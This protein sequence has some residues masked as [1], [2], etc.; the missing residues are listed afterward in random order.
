MEI[1]I[2]FLL[3]M[4]LQRLSSGPGWVA[5]GV[6][7]GAGLGGGATESRVRSVDLDAVG[8]FHH[9]SWL[10][11]TCGNP[12]HIV[13]GGDCLN[14]SCPDG[15]PASPYLD[16]LSQRALPVGLPVKFHVL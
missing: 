5:V 11:A 1:G 8:S 2:G 10:Y 15:Y 16:V 13:V 3:L 12:E 14:C 6:G 4:A 7:S 9:S